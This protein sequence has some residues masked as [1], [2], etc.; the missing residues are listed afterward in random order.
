[1]QKLISSVMVYRTFIENAF[2][3]FLV[4]L[5][6]A[7]SDKY[8]RKFPLLLVIF[9]FIIQNLLLVVCVY[10]ERSTGAMSV[11]IVSSLIV[12]LS[13][14]Q[15]CF[16]VA[17]FSYVSDHTGVEKRTMRTT[18]L[19]SCIFLGVTL[20]LGGG[21]IFSGMGFVKTF[22]IGTA[23]E[24]FAFVYLLIMMTNRANPGVTKGKSYSQM[25][26]ELFDFQHIRES[27]KSI[28]KPRE[29]NTRLKL[30]LMLFAHACVFMPMV[31]TCHKNNVNI[32]NILSFDAD[33][34][35]NC[36]EILSR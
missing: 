28:V 17:A 5:V 21:A 33:K 25:F 10:M 23:M 15:A 34:I 31:G 22:L 2:P 26:M 1:V 16:M 24:V 3:M 19:H 27:I 11:A 9:A 6:G 35:L 12:S 14:N 30:W 18:I 32:K 29:G 7:W 4:F 20:G 36:Y 8:G 13:G